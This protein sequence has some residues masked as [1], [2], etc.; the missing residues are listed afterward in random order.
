MK[1]IIILLSSLFFLYGCSS[2]PESPTTT[3]E[4][5]SEVSSIET[6]AKELFGDNITFAEMKDT[7]T[8]EIS[9]SHTEYQVI[10]EDEEVIAADK[11]INSNQGSDEDKKIIDDIKNKANELAQ[12]LDNEIDA[13]QVGY[14]EDGNI[15]LVAFNQKNKAIIE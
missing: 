8:G 15:M 3:T 1:K 5:K 13:I 2:Q 7:V 11:N 6:K 4:I 10:I 12:D 9:E 14:K